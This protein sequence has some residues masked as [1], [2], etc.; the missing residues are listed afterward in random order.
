M[1]ILVVA[2]GGNPSSRLLTAA[3]GLALRGHQVL[4]RGPWAPASALDDLRPVESDR[5]L[6]TWKADVVVS[7]AGSPLRPALLG[8]QARAFCQVLALEHARVA[9][10]SWLERFMWSSLHPQGLVEPGEAPSFQERPSGLSFEHLALWSD[11]LPAETPDAAHGDTEILERACERALAR[12]RSRASRSAAFLDRDGT[13]VREVGYLSDPA[14]LEILPGVPQALR[15]LQ[16]AGL[17]LVVISN[18]S[19]VGRGLFSIS[20]V[21]DAMA[22]LRRRLR[23]EGVEI[24][25]IYFCPH[26]PEAGC[27]CRKPGSLLLERAAE[28]LGLTLRDSYMIGDKR[29]DVETGHRVGARGLLVRTGYG[30]DEEQREGTPIEAPDAVCDDLSAAADWILAHAAAP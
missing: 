20:R 5:D 8:W 28:D 27:A 29:L 19:G 26:R 18:Q 21:Y 12:Q 13:L 30:R 11:E 7:D 24:D 9:S 17:A 10:W 4:W 22:R 23:A 2:D 14:D 1:R 16:A 15:H 3:A 25:G 6:W